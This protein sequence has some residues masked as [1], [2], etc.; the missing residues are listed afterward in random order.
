[1]PLTMSPMIG[2]SPMPPP[3]RLLKKSRIFSKK[4]PRSSS[5]PLPP[6][7][8]SGKRIS[9]RN[10]G[11]DGRICGKEL[12]DHIEHRTKKGAERGIKRRN[13]RF[14]SFGI[15][16][17]NIVID[18]TNKCDENIRL[19]GFDRNSVSAVKADTVCNDLRTAAFHILQ[20]LNE[21]SLAD[22]E[23]DRG[24]VV[25]RDVDGQGAG[26]RDNSQYPP[27]ADAAG[28]VSDAFNAK[29]AERIK[30]AFRREVQRGKCNTGQAKQAGN[31]ADDRLHVVIDNTAV[32][33][34]GKIGQDFHQRGDGR[35]GKFIKE[36]K[37]R[38]QDRH[39]T[40]NDL[41]VVCFGCVHRFGVGCGIHA[42]NADGL[43]MCTMFS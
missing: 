22:R 6:P 5:P 30:E 42:I 10:E 33:R 3:K 8:I 26:V 2:I 7:P 9:D 27:L 32:E 16:H 19:I 25:D 18:E 39:K 40:R 37:D 15:R 34:I 38:V 12:L 23:R 17:Q 4:L 35:L 36:I 43:K 28:I 21:L 31:S 1:M 14:R 41:F 13:E 11:Y 24:R 29:A 20:E